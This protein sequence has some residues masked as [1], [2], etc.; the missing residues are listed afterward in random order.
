[1]LTDPTGFL[2]KAYIVS[3]VIGSMTQDASDFTRLIATY[4][5]QQ[6]FQICQY[7]SMLLEASVLGSC[8]LLEPKQAQEVTVASHGNLFLSVM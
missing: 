2:L 3:Y 1:M 7:L 4:E 6:F 5:T 8:V